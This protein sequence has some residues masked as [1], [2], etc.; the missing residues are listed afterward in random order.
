MDIIAYVGTALLLSSRLF[1]KRTYLHLV[2]ILGNILW[3][4]Y[5]ISISNI[6]LIVTD[7]IAIIID[8]VAIYRFGEK[9]AC[10]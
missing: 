2:A 4:I 8:I 10:N 3:L 5:A 6:P 9:N 1:R 7:A